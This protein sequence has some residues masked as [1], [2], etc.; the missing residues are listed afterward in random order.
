[1]ASKISVNPEK[2]LSLIIPPKIT[3]PIPDIQLHF[4]NNLVTLEDSVKYLGITIDV[5]LNFNVHSNILARKIS[6]AYNL[7]TYIDLLKLKTF[8][9]PCIEVYN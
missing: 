3:T 4:Y 5:R 9:M 8:K 2:S 7:L 6:A 1:M